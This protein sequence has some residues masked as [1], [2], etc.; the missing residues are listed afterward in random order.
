MDLTNFEF[1]LKSTQ[2]CFPASGIDSRTGIK[3]WKCYDISMGMETFDNV[4]FEFLFVPTD[5]VPHEVEPPSSEPF[6]HELL[7]LDTS[8]TEEVLDYIDKFGI[9][10]SPL[11]NSKERFL[12]GQVRSKNRPYPTGRIMTTYEVALEARLR[13]KRLSLNGL[14]ETGFFQDAVGSEDPHRYLRRELIHVELLPFLRQD[15]EPNALNHLFGCYS[16]EYARHNCYAVDPDCKKYGGIVSLPEV[17]STLRLLQMLF[18]LLALDSF[19]KRTEVLP[20]E[21]ASY[22]TTKRYVNQKGSFFFF[23]NGKP[24]AL[25]DK[26][27]ESLA[28][29]LYAS[30]NF[31][32]ID[33]AREAAAIHLGMT[34]SD[35]IN[36]ALSNAS[37]FFDISKRWVLGKNS[38]LFHIERPPKYSPIEHL[39]A[40][41]KSQKDSDQEIAER[42]ESGSLTEVLY[43]QFEFE[44]HLEEPWVR[45]ENCGRI[46]K[47]AKESS[48]LKS[49]VIRTASYCKKSCMVSASNKRSRQL[50]SSPK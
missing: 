12:T 26:A 21:A 47:L 29:Q 36:K 19:A 7:K 42:E 32:T 44:E 38:D 15:Y 6:N 48:P 31:E 45:C 5:S 17:K 41:L 28:T 25:T 27:I 39:R 1:P 10:F 11:Y 43:G 23:E 24:K 14:N 18:P 34:L 13:E 2:S 3:K 8:N 49:K 30:G 16:S 40:L 35:E 33:K 50:N 9:P 20:S 22:L 4:E 37:M 46:F